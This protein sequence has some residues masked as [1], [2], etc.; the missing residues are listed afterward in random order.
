L[1]LKKGADRAIS[2]EVNPSEVFY[3]TCNGMAIISYLVFYVAI[4]N[5]KPTKKGKKKEKDNDVP[6]KKGKKKLHNE[7]RCLS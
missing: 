3:S 5:K 1:A 7:V 2:S 4:E 6:P